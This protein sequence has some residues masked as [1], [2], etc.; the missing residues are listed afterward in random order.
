M[1]RNWLLIGIGTLV[2]CFGITVGLLW[3]NH[4]LEEGEIVSNTARATVLI[5][6][7][8]D[9]P[10]TQALMEGCNSS[11]L[12]PD[13][14]KFL[15][16]GRLVEIPSGTNVQIPQ[17]STDGVSGPMTISDGRL[18]GTPVW[19]CRGQFSLLHPMP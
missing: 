2:V 19:V 12:P 3:V 13:A 18:E 15:T 6:L 8:D 9:P 10:V 1:R 17:W 4:V 16:S 5:A 14:K 7:T 11:A